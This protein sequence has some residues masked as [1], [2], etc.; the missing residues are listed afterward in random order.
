MSVTDLSIDLFYFAVVA[1]AD[2]IRLAAAGLL[3]VSFFYGLITVTVFV[4]RNE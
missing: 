1:L 2:V 3:T 4:I